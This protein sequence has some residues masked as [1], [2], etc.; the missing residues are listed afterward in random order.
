MVLLNVAHLSI[1]YKD[2]TKGVVLEAHLADPPDIPG[3]KFS[4]KI[5]TEIA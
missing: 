1:D 4:T 3:D 2:M 5:V